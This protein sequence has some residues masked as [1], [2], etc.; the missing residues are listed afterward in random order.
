MGKRVNAITSSGQPLPPSVLADIFA[1][2]FARPDCDGGF[3]LH[4]FPRTLEEGTLLNAV[5][6]NARCRISCVLLVTRSDKGLPPVD[7]QLVDLYVTAGSLVRLSG[8]GGPSQ[9]AEDVDSAIA[10]LQ[11]LKRQDEDFDEAPSLFARVVEKQMTSE[12][13]LRAKRAISGC[14]DDDERIYPDG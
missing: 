13:E 1:G 9:L 5:L 12:D 10:P 11:A 14:F 6:K 2:R 7:E 4:D 8:E 3:V